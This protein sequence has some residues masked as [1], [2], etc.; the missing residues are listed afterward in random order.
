VKK[1]N[2]TAVKQEDAETK[3]RRAGIAAFRQAN[4]PCGIEGLYDFEPAPEGE[5]E[6]RPCFLSGLATFK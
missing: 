2:E 4:D 6:R 3:S 1:Q 5:F